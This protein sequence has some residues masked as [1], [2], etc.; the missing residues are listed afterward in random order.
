MTPTTYD[1]PTN[2]RIQL[3]V[4]TPEQESM[5]A[6][7][8]QLYARDFSAFHDVTFDAAGKFV[9]EPL[10][11]YWREPGRFPFLFELDGEVA[12]FVLVKKNEALSADDAIWDIAEFFVLHHFRRRGVG[13]AVANAVWRRFPGNWEIRVMESN[14]AACKFWVHAIAYF[15]HGFTQD[16]QIHEGGQRWK[17]LA[18]ESAGA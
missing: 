10:P 9:Y 4:A 3:I 13:T 17:V 5:L 7:L 18:F 15:G 8:L 16:M 1:P 14:H 6:N 2:P 11:L 12:G